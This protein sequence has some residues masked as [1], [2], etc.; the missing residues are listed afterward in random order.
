MTLLEQ[1]SRYLVLGC[2]NMEIDLDE[3]KQKVGARVEDIYPTQIKN[4]IENNY[5]K[6]EGNK[7]KI[8]PYGKA[9]IIDVSRAFF[10]ENN[11]DFTQPQYDIL[12]MFEGNREH[13]TDGVVQNGKKLILNNYINNKKNEMQD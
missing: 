8:T 2:K 1:I 3:F 11:V 10:T 13:F 7:L 4:L 5:I 6:I 12:D 9:W